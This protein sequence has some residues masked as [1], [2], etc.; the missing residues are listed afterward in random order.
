MTDS[1]SPWVEKFE[2]FPL[3]GGIEIILIDNMVITLIITVIRYCLLLGLL[4][5]LLFIISIIIIISSIEAFVSMM[6]QSQSQKSLPGG[7]GV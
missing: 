5:V 4:S 1:Q 2:G 7:G 3:H 6:V